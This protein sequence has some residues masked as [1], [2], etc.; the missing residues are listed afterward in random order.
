MADART[1]LAA[2]FDLSGAIHECRN[3]ATYL[4]NEKFQLGSAFDRLTTRST[5]IMLHEAVIDAQL[6][7]DLQAA[8]DQLARA[9]ALLMAAN[10]K[11]ERREAIAETFETFDLLDPLLPA[12]AG[13]FLA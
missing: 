6:A 10:R 11:S 5:L 3:S 2:L 12:S 4:S 8:Q 13:P 9:R 7:D 1:L